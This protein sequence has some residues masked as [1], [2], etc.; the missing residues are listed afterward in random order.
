MQPSTKNI[1]LQ[2]PQ[3]HTSA[4]FTAS[5]HHL[6]VAVMILWKHIAEHVTASRMAFSSQT[7]NM[8]PIHKNG[9]SPR[10]DCTRDE[11]ATA[12]APAWLLGRIQGH[13]M[14]HVAKE[15]AG[16]RWSCSFQCHLL[17]YTVLPR[18]FGDLGYGD[19]ENTPDFYTHS[20]LAMRNCSGSDM[21][22]DTR[23]GDLDP[24][25]ACQQ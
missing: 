19:L 14:R 15:W 3:E 2:P 9:I 12:Y 17:F 13:R 6:C 21:Y 16:S 20:V 10:R 23:Y 18:S 5:I 25:T 11:T 1:C 8:L 7:F 24:H 4:V 22:G